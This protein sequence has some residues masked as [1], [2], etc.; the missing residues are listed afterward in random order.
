MVI[1]NICEK[2]NRVCNV[3]Y[4]QKNFEN[5][6]SGDNNIDK[7]I[8][9]TQLL[10]HN[11]PSNALEWIPYYKLYN[12]K[13]IAKDELGEVYR[14]NWIDGNINNW[15]YHIQNWQRINQNMFVTLK[16]LN[17]S[18][19]FALEFIN[20]VYKKFVYNENIKNSNFY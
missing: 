6:T 14:A 3:K 7:L 17:N 19:S 11:H 15:D 10:A 20:E 18:K 16:S 12:I 13:Y 2:C 5:W 8:K 1:L 9:D 4:F